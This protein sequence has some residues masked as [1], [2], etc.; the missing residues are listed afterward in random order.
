MRRSPTHRLPRPQE[1]SSYCNRSGCGTS[2]CHATH[3]ERL[4]ITHAVHLTLVLLRSEAA[5][6]ITAGTSSRLGSS[7]GNLP[8]KS[9]I[10]RAIF[11]RCVFEREMSSIQELDRRVRIVASERFGA[12]GNKVKVVQT[13]RTGSQTRNCEGS[14][15]RKTHCQLLMNAS[16][17]ALMTSACV[18]IIPCGKSLYVFSVPFLRSLAESGPAA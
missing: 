16:K 4:R 15:L 13:K 3:G 14:S 18:V 8:R 2:K 17:S 7:G 10:A 12:C 6:S 5:S 9:H 1:Q 11:S